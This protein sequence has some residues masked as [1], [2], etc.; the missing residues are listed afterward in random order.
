MSETPEEVVEQPIDT[1]I[2][3][4][5]IEKKIED[6]AGIGETPAE[7]PA[8]TKYEPKKLEIKDDEIIKGPEDLETLSLDEISQADTP[9]NVTP[10]QKKAAEVYEA[11]LIEGTPE[12]IAA[13]GTL[14]SESLVGNI[15]GEVSEKS[16]AQA[17]TGELDKRA[18]V[19]YQLG[20]LFKSFDE[21][22]E[23]PAWASPAMRKVTSM[24]QSRGL[25]AS[26][27]ASAA[28]TQA[29]ME[30]G[31]PIA[32][33]DAKSYSQIQLTNLN[34]QQQATL[35]NAMTYA[36]M[37]KANL[38]ARLRTA[39]NNAQSFLQIDLTNLSNEQKMA[40]LDYQ[41]RLQTLTSNQAAENAAAQFNAKSQNQVDQF[42]EQLNASIESANANRVAAQQQFNVSQKNAMTQ[43]FEGLNNDRQKFNQNMAL[44]IEQS[45]VIW[46][47]EE[48][49]ANTAADNEA[50]RINAQN[51]YNLTNASQA[52]IWQAYR[53]DVAYILQTAENELDRAHQFAILGMQQD[54]NMDMFETELFAEAITS[55]VEGYIL[56][57]IT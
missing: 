24:M 56:K 54:G 15:Q 4:S 47:R 31:I 10:P 34:N 18:T 3:G 57:K 40:E 46:R 16:I 33:S 17:A 30:A 7:L 49:T 37:D 53:D 21:G 42:Y 45:N 6:Q 48:N 27:M 23:P 20:E 39:V 29:I 14:S 11:T 13:K 19:K 8:G 51:L 1:R 36:A 32:A 9:P 52:A 44:Q 5:K 26:S 55:A 43:F 22:K 12:A 28:M 25:G 38:D 35:Q 41:G 2:S 50:M